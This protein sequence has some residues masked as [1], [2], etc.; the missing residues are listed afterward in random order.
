MLYEFRKF[1]RLMKKLVFDQKHGMKNKSKK[2]QNKYL[3]NERYSKN[4][5]TKR[6]FGH[7]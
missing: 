1:V 2:S 7:K 4:E 3:S 5:T 6:Y